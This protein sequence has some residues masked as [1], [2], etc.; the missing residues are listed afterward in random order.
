MMSVKP[1][2]LPVRWTMTATRL[3][4]QIQKSP[5][6]IITIA[7]QV[8]VRLAVKSVI[9]IQIALLEHVVVKNCV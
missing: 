8:T 3:S 6:P 4:A 7:F 9:W 2:E 5:V 1:K